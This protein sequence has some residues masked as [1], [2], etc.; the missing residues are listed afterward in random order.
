MTSLRMRRFRRPFATAALFCLVFS[1]PIVAQEPPPPIGPF[2]IDVRGAFPMFPDAAELA[3]SRGLPATS[4]PGNGLGID[5]GAH[6][7]LFAWKAVT[8]GLGAQLLLARAKYTPPI[9]N[10]VPF[11]AAV[12]ERFTSFSPQLSLNFGSGHGWSYLSGGLGGSVWSIIPEGS[13]PRAADE[14]RLRTYNYGGGARWFAKPHLAFTFDVRFYAV[15]PGT[16]ASGFIGSPR[17]SFLVFAAG[18]AL[19]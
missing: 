16:P 4:L 14:E 12:T 1:S 15:D 2:V 3:Q 10:N 17:S 5:A 9:V 19:K 7:Y 18:V 11:G 8:I 13:D 6:V